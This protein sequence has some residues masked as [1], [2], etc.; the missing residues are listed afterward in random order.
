MNSKTASFA[1]FYPCTLYYKAL[2]RNMAY[3]AACH[4]E[5]RSEVIH[6]PSRAS[7]RRTKEVYYV[8]QTYITGS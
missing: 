5:E 6:A 7:Q 3:H 4:N 1:F 2:Y 8:D